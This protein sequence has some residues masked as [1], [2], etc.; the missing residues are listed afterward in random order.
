M[1]LLVLVLLVVMPLA[2]ICWQSSSAG[3]VLLADS[4]G[5]GAN[6]CVTAGFISAGP[7]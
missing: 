5:W 4:A 6:G 7:S 1:V 2:D 3:L